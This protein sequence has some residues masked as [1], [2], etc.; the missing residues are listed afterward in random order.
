M[1][2]LAAG[3][4]LLDLCC[5]TGGFSISAM[6]AGAAS[7]TAVDLDEKALATARAN[8]TLNQVTVDF[9]QVNAFDFLRSAVAD[10]RQADLAV[11]DPAK[12]AAVKDEVPRA[13]RTYGDLNTLA[14]QV[15]RP[16]GVLV[17]CS[18]S[19][20]IPPETFLSILRNSARDAGVSLQVFREAG[21]APD[22]PVRSEFPEGR[23]LKVVYA[24][25]LP[26]KRQ[27]LEVR[28]AA[29]PSTRPEISPR[30]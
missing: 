13:M 28:D 9:R 29:R 7:C 11:V 1:A 10:G 14:M 24:R 8:A 6:K 20:L 23:Y 27:R 25:V 15:V 17:T 16:G 30:S 2:A 4:G 26:G 5:Y 12:L 22:H 21:A 19:G 18:C 3:K